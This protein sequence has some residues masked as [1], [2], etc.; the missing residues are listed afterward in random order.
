[1]RIIQTMRRWLSAL[2]RRFVPEPVPRCDAETVQVFEAALRP[3]DSAIDV[4]CNRGMCLPEFQRL[5]PEGTHF[6]FEPLPHLHRR[7]ANL[8]PRV[9]CEQ[10]AL[11]DREGVLPY[12]FFKDR[13]GFSGLNRRKIDA[14]EDTIE[15][16]SVRTARMDDVVPLEAPVRVIKIDVEGAELLVLQGAEAI[17]R[18]WRP[19]VVFECGRGALDSFG[20][21]PEQVYDFL[22]GLQFKV[23]R[24]EGWSADSPAFS[25]DS[26]VEEFW[27]ASNSMFVASPD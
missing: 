1:M 21:Q 23:R 22:V 6:A 3:S 18:R 24:L 10:I 5:S 17:L 11:S 19:V 7:L 8:F 12:Y 16:L 14:R 13:D 15:E 26:F 25:R 27:H 4:G 9:R 20:F 2:Y